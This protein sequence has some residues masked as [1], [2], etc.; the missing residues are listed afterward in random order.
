MMKI[1]L[2]DQGH[3]QLEDV[4]KTTSDPRLRARCQAI[5]MAH[6][7]RRHR[8]I[9][10]DLGLSTRTLQRWLSA[11]QIQGLAGLKIR[12]VPGRKAKIPEAWAP[13]IL[14]WIKVGPAGCGL[15]RANWT[16]A[17]LATYLYQTKGV[18]VGETTMRLFC[19][20]HGVRPYRPSY[21]YLKADSAQQAQAEQD[22]QILKKS[23]G[24]GACAAESG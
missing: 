20:R 22:L 5:L 7:G 15:D 9:A 21:Q 6:R 18:T 12:W 16:Y 8:H 23:R 13:E 4:F 17:E 2:S 14:T 11:Y 1:T 3:R 24:G 19:Q 10:E